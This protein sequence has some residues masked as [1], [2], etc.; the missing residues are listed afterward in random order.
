MLKND[1][2]SWDYTKDPCSSIAGFTSKL[3]KALPTHLTTNHFAQPLLETKYLRPSS[4]IYRRQAI[5]TQ[6][7][8]TQAQLDRW[9][10]IVL[11]RGATII[12]L[13]QPNPIQ[14][15]ALAGGRAGGQGLPVDTVSCRLAVL[16]PERSERRCNNKIP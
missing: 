7:Y 9:R 14:S 8:L 12:K 4:I 13:N 3:I 1:K 5:Q 10:L 6:G 15:K 2:D 11:E 16:S